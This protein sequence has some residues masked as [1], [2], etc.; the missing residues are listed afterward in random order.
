MKTHSLLLAALALG[1]AL[2]AAAQETPLPRQDLTGSLQQSYR[3]QAG[4]ALKGFLAALDRPRP[5][6]ATPIP[7]SLEAVL[8]RL[9]SDRRASPSTHAHLTARQLFPPVRPRARFYAALPIGSEE[10]TESYRPAWELLLL[11]PPSSGVAQ[12]GY[13]HAAVAL[14]TIGNPE[15]LVVAER[16]FEILTASETALDTWVRDREKALFELMLLIPGPQSLAGLQRCVPL[17]QA[18]RLRHPEYRDPWDPQTHLLEALRGLIDPGLRQRWLTAVRAAQGR[19][20]AA[21]GPLNEM[22]A[23]LLRGLAP[24]L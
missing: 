4:D 20:G 2:P 9:A 8:A 6:A 14:G 5:G 11:L 16:A 15:S 23:A 17:A 22:E 1:L 13:H 24:T 21:A 10:L 18:Q 19:P 3:S 7:G 12:G